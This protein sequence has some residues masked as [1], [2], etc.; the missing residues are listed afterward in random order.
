MRRP[1]LARFLSSLFALWFV[2]VLGDP[3]VLHACPEHGGHSA[4]GAHAAHQMS[5]GNHNT[6]PSAPATT[7]GCTCIGSCCA[8]PTLARL[9]QVAS[10]TVAPEIIPEIG[11]PE[12]PVSAPAPLPERLLPF[13]NGP[14]QV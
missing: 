1:P 7:S 13:A 11:Q 10:F 12:H 2:V 3:G 4:P 9:P 5:G 6:A 8:A 14:P